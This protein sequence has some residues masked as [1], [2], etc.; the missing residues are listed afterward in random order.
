MPDASKPIQKS[1]APSHLV[2]LP[3]LSNSL[4]ALPQAKNIAHVAV[5]TSGQHA[6][7]S[8]AKLK[9]ALSNNVGTAQTL[10]Y[11]TSPTAVPTHNQASQQAL[12]M[13]KPTGVTGY[14]NTPLPLPHCR[15]PSYHLPLLALHLRRTLSIPLASA[16]HILF[17]A[18]YNHP[19]SF[20]VLLA[21]AW[22]GIR[23]S[24]QTRAGDRVGVAYLRY[25]QYEYGFSPFSA[26]LRPAVSA[27]KSDVLVFLDSFFGDTPISVAVYAA[28]LRHLLSAFHFLSIAHEA[29]AT[30]DHS[31]VSP[32]RTPL[33]YER[34]KP[35]SPAS[36]SDLPTG[37]V[38]RAV[39]CH[40]RRRL[41]L[42]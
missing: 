27:P 19:G 2:S 15:I 11:A 1:S 13:R 35:F 38:V 42:P 20:T 12:M 30:S 37:I 36:R 5:Y 34:D 16:S 31:I 33:P 23:G 32:I 26:L 25:G 24:M 6:A 14:W 7:E 21:N 29:I 40:V 18:T 17:S 28:V 39:N 4:S 3:S 22:L 8:E 10:A 9:K 41:P